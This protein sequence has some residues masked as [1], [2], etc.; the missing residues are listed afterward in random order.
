MSD[1]VMTAADIDAATL[2]AMRDQKEQTSRTDTVVRIDQVG[3]YRIRVLPNNMA[4]D[5]TNFAWSR[6]FAMHFWK[7]GLIGNEKTIIFNSAKH[8]LGLEK[9]PI[10]TAVDRAKQSG[11][12]A[13]EAMADNIRSGP[14]YLVNAMILRPGETVGDI[15]A[16]QLNK[17]TWDNFV[18]FGQLVMAGFT[19]LQSN[20][21]LT[22]EFK[23]FPNGNGIFGEV[24][25]REEPV[26]LTA[27]GITPEMLHDLDD[28]VAEK[29]ANARHPDT[30]TGDLL[31]PVAAIAAALPAAAVVAA[32]AL[33]AA[34]PAALPAPAVASPI[35]ES[36]PVTVAPAVE[37][38]AAPPPVATAPA[39]PAP[40]APVP[41]SPVAAP[42]VEATTEPA[43]VP[44]PAPVAEQ[45]VAPAEAAP[46]KTQAEI[47]AELATMLGNS[48]GPLASVT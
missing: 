16:L 11:N 20:I 14:S 4:K 23:K 30:F 36:A 22:V 15:I 44:A 17:T 32:P 33:L 41:A 39:A 13:L 18:N 26:D 10:I 31:N 24:V 35:V 2:A 40:T 12:P 29:T 38:V 19:Y 25:A 42:V 46:V 27:L 7:K 3:E 8:T 28:V 21:C 45:P 43:P 48:D 1:T 47:D 6:P 34:G 5:P 9:D 37:A